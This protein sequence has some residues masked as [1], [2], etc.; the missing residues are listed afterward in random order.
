MAGDWVGTCGRVWGHVLGGDGMWQ[1]L[2]SCGRVW[3]HV[4]GVEACHKG[5]GHMAGA[6][7]KCQKVKDV[8]YE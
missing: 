3:C 8:D 2:G 7:V 1:G 5:W 4:A 6:Y